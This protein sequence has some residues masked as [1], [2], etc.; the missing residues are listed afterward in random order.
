MRSAKASTTEPRDRDPAVY[1]NLSS[2]VQLT[3]PQ[4]SHPKA[5]DQGTAKPGQ[6]GFWFDLSKS[7]K[8]PSYQECIDDTSGG[9]PVCLECLSSERFVVVVVGIEGGFAR[10]FL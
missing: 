5:L 7:M 9:N 2:R 4:S 6:E 1:Q 10:Y 8:T 3:P